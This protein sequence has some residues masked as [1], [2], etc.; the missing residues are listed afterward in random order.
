[1]INILKKAISPIMEKHKLSLELK[2]STDKSGKFDIYDELRFNRVLSL[3]CGFYHD[4]N[5]QPVVFVGT[6]VATHSGCSYYTRKIVPHLRAN[7]NSTK[8]IDYHYKG[9]KF[10]RIVRL[11]N[12]QTNL[13]FYVASYDS[14]PELLKIFN[15][16][17]I[18]RPHVSKLQCITN[19][20][21]FEA[22]NPDDWAK[23]RRYNQKYYRWIETASIL[24]RFDGTPL[25]NANIDELKQILTPIVEKHIRGIEIIDLI[26]P[27]RD[28]L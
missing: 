19:L 14:L 12:L 15:H 27:V 3:T 24:E 9:C 18:I 20:T 1:M 23:L 26:C 6:L 16:N 4:E 25:A 21:N 28:N 11:N 8:T 10:E 22:K 13:R 5:N 2:F 7:P 17:P